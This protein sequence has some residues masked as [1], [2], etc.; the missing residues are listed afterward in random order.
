[1][2]ISTDRF[3]EIEADGDAPFL[4]ANAGEILSFLR[5]NAEK[6]FRQNRISKRHP[7]AEHLEK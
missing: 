3:E 2:R 1:M 4:G 6:A 5:T 7:T